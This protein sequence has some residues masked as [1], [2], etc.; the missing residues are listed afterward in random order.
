MP[1]GYSWHPIED[2]EADPN[3]LTDGEMESLWSRQKSELTELQTLDEFSKRLR[4]EWS[5][6]TGVIEKAYTL[7][8]SGTRT[9]IERG[10]D[11]G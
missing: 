6:E 11:A 10:I 8:R 1:G 5:I 4:R 3:S 9:L 2:F 7:D